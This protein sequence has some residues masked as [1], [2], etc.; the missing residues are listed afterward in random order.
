MSNV[1]RKKTNRIMLDD[2]LARFPNASELQMNRAAL[3]KFVELA[4]KRV[5][6]VNGK[7]VYIL[8]DGHSTI[9]LVVNQ[10]IEG[11]DIFVESSDA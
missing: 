5:G 2:M 4:K 10:R 6:K 9:S 1:S 3:R 8:V 11:E 7:P